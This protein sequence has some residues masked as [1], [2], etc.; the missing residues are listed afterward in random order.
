MR[1]TKLLFVAL[2]AVVAAT[3]CMK[4]DKW[5]A[6]EDQAEVK[7]PDVTF[8]H[9]IHADQGI[10]CADCHQGVEKATSL[11]ERHLPTTAKCQECHDA[12]PQYSVPAATAVEP[13]ISFSHAQHL[14]LVKN[15]CAK[16]HEKLPEPG[17][18]RFVPSMNT[19]TSCHNHQKDFNEARCMP[20][21]VDLKGFPLVPEQAFAHQ[22]DWLR[23]H[24]NLA[25]PTAQSCAACH[26]QTYCAECHAASTTP[27]RPSIV[28]PEEV[29]RDFIHRGD[30]VS[31]HMIE[32]GA[33]PASCL[34]CHGRPFCDSCH[35]QQN[36]T[37]NAIDPRNPHPDGW[38]TQASGEWHGDAARRNIAGC[39]GCHDQG[40]DSL[41]V[42]CHQVGGIADRPGV[43][44]GPHPRSFV[45]KHR[46]ENKS[47]PPCAA[48]HR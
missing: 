34:R 28:F 2:L 32:A 21:H 4:K 23:I 19:C 29:Q 6:V 11:R 37:T 15:D 22:G 46:G 35:T 3:G 44:N 38:M 42:T 7:R 43:D 12:S 31:R 25:R 18:A 30:Y 9:S 26:D 8:P 1:R 17:Q 27:A 14:G 41:C 39:A 5:V 13:R 16:C 24:A 47:K 36:L 20:C 33:N 45:S 48:C 10:E 40:A